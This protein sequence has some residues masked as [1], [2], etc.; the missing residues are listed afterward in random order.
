MKLTNRQAEAI[1]LMQCGWQL[2]KTMTFVT[3]TRDKERAWLQKGGIGKGGDSVHVNMNTF[4]A[5][6]K[7]GMIEQDKQDMLA[8]PKLYKLTQKGK[9]Y[10]KE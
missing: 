6:Y 5:L 7:A 4:Y 2:G 8:R 3:S 10:G 1:V 9:E